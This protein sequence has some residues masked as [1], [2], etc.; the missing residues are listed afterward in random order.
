MG[1]GTG[2]DQAGTMKEGLLINILRG[3]TIVVNATGVMYTNSFRLPRGVTFGWE[4]QFTGSPIA[5]TVELEQ[6]NQPPNTEGAQDDAFVI[7]VNKATTNGLFPT[8]QVVGATRYQTAYSPN[9]TE[10]ARLKFT[11]TGAN[12]ANTT[13]ILARVYVIKN[14]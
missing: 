4:V 1:G 6:S 3:A 14:T 9:A 12:A 2:V 11:G 5:V 10:Y 8:G 7:P 13:C